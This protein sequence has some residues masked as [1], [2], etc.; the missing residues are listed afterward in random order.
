MEHETESELIALA[1]SSD[2]NAFGQLIERYSLMV[3]RIAASM[4]ADTECAREMAQEA[5]L[6][7]YLSLDHLRDDTRFK[8]WL[9]GIT[10]NVCRSFLR[11]Q[12]QELSLEA[13]LGGTHKS[14]STFLE[15][16]D[17]VDPQAIVEQQE[18]HQIVVRAVEFLSPK[19]RVA[20][21][22]FYYEQL[23]LQEIATLLDISVG[24]V[25]G[26]LHRARQHLR[27]QL[28]SL[29]PLMLEQTP[30]QLQI[31]SKGRRKAM[32]PARIHSIREDPTTKLNVVIV[33]D[34][35][36]RHMVLIWVGQTEAT[37]IAASF[38]ELPVPRP[39]TAQ[40]MANLLKVVGT[41][42]EEVRIEALKDEVYYAV[43]K[44]RTGDTVQEVDARPSDALAL[45][46]LMESPL[47]IAEEVMER[48]GIALPEG[49]TLRSNTAEEKENLRIDIRKKWAE[50]IGAVHASSQES[51]LETQK[52]FIDFLIWDV[53]A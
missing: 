10:L 24:A 12:Q 46:L 42:V 17:V 19:D 18:L 25:K 20:A 47:F 48:V 28:V 33:Q 16:I 4:I 35:P 27:E 7:A 21:L 49:K 22:L 32:I 11:S 6:Q 8:S 40:L 30:E 15:G 14:F 50:K 23:S 29:D 5:V 36:G 44:V 1:R 13:L 45:A 52:R 39:M 53:Q 3:K 31:A 37:A 43:I 9:Y 26:R 41:R 34:E 2:K 38:S 51:I